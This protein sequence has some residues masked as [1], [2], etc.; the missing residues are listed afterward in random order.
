MIKT[1]ACPECGCKKYLNKKLVGEGYRMCEKCHQDWWV[2]INYM[3][4][5]NENNT[6]NNLQ[7]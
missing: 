1:S 6:N 2:D 7:M 4:N 5:Q 3:E